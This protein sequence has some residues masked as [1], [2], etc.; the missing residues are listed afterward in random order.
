[1]NFETLIFEKR[2]DGPDVESGTV[3]VI[4]DQQS[5]LGRQILREVGQNPAGQRY[6]TRFNHDSRCFGK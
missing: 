5:V 6:V 3:D 2:D 1:M 4:D